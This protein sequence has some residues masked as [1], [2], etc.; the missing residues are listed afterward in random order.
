[1]PTR[2]AVRPSMSLTMNPARPR[3]TVTPTVPSSMARCGEALQA[4]L[5]RRVVG[6]A[7]VAERR[8]AGE[9]HDPAVLLLHPC[10]SGTDRLI[11]KEPRSGRSSPGPSRPRS[12]GNS[13][14]SRVTPALFTK[15]STAPS[16]SRTRLTAVSNRGGVAT[17]QATPIAFSP[18]EP[19]GGGAGRRLASRSRTATAAPSTAKRRA[20]AAPMPLAGPVTTATRPAKRLMTAHCR[21]GARARR[22][23]G[24]VA[25]WSQAVSRAERLA[26]PMPQ[27]QVPLRA[28]IGAVMACAA[29]TVAWTYDLRCATR[30]GSAGPTYSVSR[31]AGHWP[32]SATWCTRNCGVRAAC[33]SCA[34][35]LRAVVAPSAG[36]ASSVL[37]GSSGWAAWY[38][39]YVAFRNLKS[40]VPFV[41]GSCGTT[42]SPAGQP[43]LEAT[44][45]AAGHC[46]RRS[47][48]P[49]WPPD[50]LSAVL[51]RR[52]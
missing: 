40:F 29:F 37:R 47:W 45:P 17:S 18:P 46:T 27:D 51:Q 33:V 42:S 12:S 13:R 31:P 20:V 32:S 11:R 30:T 39:T 3:L 35:V 23:Q 4:H 36:P 38:V 7:A 1:M 6:L 52:V 50:V 22:G 15:M 26:S 44:I 8:D 16:S 43:A 48:A 14:L 25:R 24:G 10:A 9:V 49:A 41:T 21:R 34:G 19:L 5:G 28:L 2:G